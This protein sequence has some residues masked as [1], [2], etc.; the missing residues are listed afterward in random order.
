MQGLTF[1]RFEDPNKVT[2]HLVEGLQMF[3]NI[4]SGVGK[5]EVTEDEL[6]D[7][8]DRNGPIIVAYDHTGC[9]VSFLQF[10]EARFDMD[11]HME[12][13]PQGSLVNYHVATLT[14]LWAGKADPKACAEMSVTIEKLVVGLARYT[15]SQHGWEVIPVISGRHH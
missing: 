13:A 6:A 2:G 4:R 9:V 11:R 15:A 12:P 3:Y 10:F 8:V 7:C 14:P 5:R 1:E